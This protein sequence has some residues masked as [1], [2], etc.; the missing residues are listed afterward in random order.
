L[1][2]PPI[3]FDFTKGQVYRGPVEEDKHDL[4]RD[5]MRAVARRLMRR[6]KVTLTVAGTP[7]PKSRL[8]Q[9]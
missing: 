4:V 3:I 5:L 1:S 2:D 7:P 6:P 8:N 9:N